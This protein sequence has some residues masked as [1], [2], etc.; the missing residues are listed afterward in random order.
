MLY[1]WPYIS[2]FSFPLILPY[3]M[4]SA[5]YYFPA[6]KTLS[7]RAALH[8][9]DIPRLWVLAGF[10][11]TGAVVVYFNTIIHP[12]TLADNRHYVFYVFRI[13]LRHWSVKYLVTPVYVLCGWLVV[14][15]L[16]SIKT[17]GRAI[18]T[19]EPKASNI[20]SKASSETKLPQEEGCCVSFVLVWL[21]TSALSLVTAP[22]VEPRYFIIPW[23]IWRLHLPVAS[24]GALQPKQATV[25]TKD[26]TQVDKGGNRSYFVQAWPL[27]METLWYL[28][29]NAVTG[30]IFLYR[31]FTWLQ[32]PENTQ[33][34]MW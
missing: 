24:I 3:I 12:F 33:R 11:I 22:L 5:S 7:G 30:Y 6:L 16:G 34:F 8:W 1:I 14:R 10:T 20:K 29:I 15:S 4:G 13:L 28:A 31:E 21:S 2:F 23:I 17:A 26:K 9:S 18:E 32:E 19:S 25:D 27:I